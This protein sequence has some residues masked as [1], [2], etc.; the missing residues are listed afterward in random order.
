MEHSK[1]RLVTLADTRY[2]PVLDNNWTTKA[3]KEKQIFTEELLK[4]LEAPS[5]G[6][7]V[8]YDHHRDAP[9]GFGYRITAKNARVFFLRYFHQGRERKLTIGDHGKN[10]WSLAAARKEAGNLKQTI[11]RGTDIVEQRRADRA[12]QTFADVAEDYCIRHAE[13][14]KSAAQVRGVLDNHALPLL[15]KR[16]LSTMLGILKASRI[17]LGYDHI[18]VGGWVVGGGSCLQRIVFNLAGR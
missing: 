8:S 16:K 4:A 2:V 6:Y 17:S 3:T 1:C 15:D 18:A 9:R 12:E 11:D 14:L 5:R 7:T 10:L 13:P